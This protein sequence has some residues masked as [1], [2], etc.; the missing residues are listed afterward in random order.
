MASTVSL[1]FTMLEPV[2][3]LSERTRY[4][5]RGWLLLGFLRFFVFTLLTF[6]HD[7]SPW[8]VASLES[9]DNFN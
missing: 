5:R 6:G 4:D 2:A 3:S 8:V 9:Y 1:D 7:I